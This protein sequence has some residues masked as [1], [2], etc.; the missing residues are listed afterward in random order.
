[1]LLTGDKDTIPITV[2]FKKYKNAKTI[3]CTL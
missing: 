3:D 1:M 2:I